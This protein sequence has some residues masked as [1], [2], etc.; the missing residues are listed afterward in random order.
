[1]GMPLPN[2]RAHS[3]LT[4]GEHTYMFYFDIILSVIT[5]ALLCLCAEIKF[6]RAVQRLNSPLPTVPQTLINSLARIKASLSPLLLSGPTC[7]QL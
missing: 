6:C 5:E 7:S 1:M 4:G 2:F 3:E